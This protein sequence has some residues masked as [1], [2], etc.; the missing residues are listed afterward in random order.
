[1]AHRRQGLL[2]AALSFPAFVMSQFLSAS[3]LG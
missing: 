1:M 2:A 3:A